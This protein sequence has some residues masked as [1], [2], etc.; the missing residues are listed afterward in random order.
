[1]AL[2][3]LERELPLERVALGGLRDD[4]VAAM[5]AALE[6]RPSSAVLG[7]AMRRDTAGNPL[8]VAQLLRHLEDEGVLVQRDGELSLAALP[9]GLGVPDSAKEL[10]AARLAALA[11]EIASA[12]R[13]AAVIGRS[14]DHELVAAVDGRPADEVLDALEAGATAGLVEEVGSGRHAFVH[15][16]VREAIYEQSGA[17]RR[18]GLHRRVAEAVEAAPGA[19]PAELAH[20]FLAAGDLE[21]GLEYSVASAERALGQL[22]YEDAAAHYGH[23]LGE[24]D[25]ERRCDLL[26]ALGDARA[27]AGDT[28]DAKRA[29]REA[30]DLADRLDA[31]HRLAVAA[32]GYGGRLL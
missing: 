23:A 6:G 26:L 17:A 22:A 16:L 3:D 5:I 31:P 9:A 8:F 15:A 32:I 1:R 18:R 29:Y 4:E 7:S 21:K 30:A 28:A 2:G 12:L 27:R 11:D 10:V 20:H 19:D 13:I 14:F 24:A 25:G